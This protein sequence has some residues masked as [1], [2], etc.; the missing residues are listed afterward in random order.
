[1]RWV[2]LAAAALSLAA[3]LLHATAGPEHFSEWWGY[4]LFF[5]AAALAQTLFGLLV[6]T[7]GISPSYGGWA[8]ARRRVYWIGI[9]GNLLILALWLVTRTI[10]IPFGP[11]AGL[12]EPIGWL[13]GATKVA[14]VAVIGLLIWLLQEESRQVPA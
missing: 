1:M 4:G 14:E 11:Q 5:V 3:G 2:E 6:A 12:V 7:Q 9:V 13:D 10:G 8:G